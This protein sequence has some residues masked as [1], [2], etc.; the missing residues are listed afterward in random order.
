[1]KDCQHEWKIKSED[2]EEK[3]YPDSYITW[4]IKK[5]KVVVVQCK[6]CTI[7]KIIR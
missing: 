3:E 1:M 7:V 2:F 5:V 6:K 4:S